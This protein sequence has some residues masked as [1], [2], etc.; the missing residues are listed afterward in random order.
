LWAGFKLGRYLMR[1]TRKA[2]SGDWI[3]KLVYKGIGAALPMAPKGQTSDYSDYRLGGGRK[4]YHLDGN[5]PWCSGTLPRAVADYPNVFYFKGAQSLCVNLFAPSE[6]TWNC[7]GTE[8]KLEQETAFPEADSTGLTIHPSTKVT[9]DLKIRVPRWCQQA[10]VSVNG[11][12]HQITRE[13]GMWATIERTWSADDRVTIRLPMRLALSPIDQQHPNCVARVY[14]P[15]VLVRE[16]SPVLTPK[17]ND[18][19]A[20]I[21]AAGQLLEFTA[22]GE[23]PGTFLPFY[24]M[25]AGT[26]YN[27]YF[28]LKV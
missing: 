21:A 24:R 17:G 19:S 4:I 14:G 18:P 5:W 15:V 22:L 2:K 11:S 13:P 12:P 20:W 7:D 25:G 16:E 8:V 10:S 9:F 23:V 28:N 6:V 26:P 27:M 1:F 3:E